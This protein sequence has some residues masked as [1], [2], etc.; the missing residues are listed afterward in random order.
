MV[1]DPSPDDAASLWVVVDKGRSLPASYVPDPLTQPKVADRSGLGEEK[2][3]RSD[4]ASAMEAMFKSASD[5]DINLM[6]TSGYRSYATQQ[7]IYA[8]YAKTSGA[9]AADTFSAHAGYS[10]HQ[11]GLAADVEPA[12]GKCELGQC[13]GETPEGK[14]LSSNCYKYGFIIRYTAQTQ[15]L[16]GYIAEPWHIRFLGVELATKLQNSGQTLEQYF[17]LPTY[18]TYSSSPFLLQ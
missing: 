10:E 15:N 9:S 16:T 4:A 14:W 12:S 5:A 11:T 3:L 17:K 6:L 1:G 8:S 13:F 7:Q 18:L 2:L